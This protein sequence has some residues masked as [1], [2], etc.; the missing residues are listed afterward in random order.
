MEGA[1]RTR[2]DAPAME[3]L[4]R[5][6]HLTVREQADFTVEDLRAHLQTMV[7]APGAPE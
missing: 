7:G 3:M 2:P 5:E 6:P 4:T 1:N